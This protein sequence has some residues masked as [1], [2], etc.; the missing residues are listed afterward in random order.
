MSVI[1]LST[2]NMLVE[3][4]E[5]GSLPSLSENV[6]VAEKVPPKAI[7]VTKKAIYKGDCESYR[8]LIE[9]YDWDVEIAMNVCRA[10]SGGKIDVVNWKDN[11]KVCM[12]STGLF[13]IGCGNATI[14]DMKNP[15]K[16]VAMAYKLYKARNWKPWGVCTSG[17]VNCF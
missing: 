13:Q 10:E 5:T 11:H 6:L 17:I 2:P 3:A 14:E 8:N 7:V 15:D 16:N 12:G 9:Q 4:P 1:G